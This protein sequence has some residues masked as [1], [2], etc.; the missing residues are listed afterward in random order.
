MLLRTG[1]FF[2]GHLSSAIEHSKRGWSMRSVAQR[3]QT[4]TASFP[5][6][7]VSLTELGNA[8]LMRL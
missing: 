8:F 2:I 5:L 7:A 1:N 4:L 6:M 3:L